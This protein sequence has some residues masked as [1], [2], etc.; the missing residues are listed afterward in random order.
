MEKSKVVICCI[1]S[2]YIHSS[3]APWCLYA[4]VKKYCDNNV[5]PIV[6]EGTINEKIENIKQRLLNEKPDIIGFCSYIWNINTVYDLAKFIKE[7]LPETKVVLGGPEVSYNAKNILIENKNVDFIVSGEGEE[8][9]AK[10]I[11]AIVNRKEPKNIKGVCYKSETELIISEPEILDNDPVSPYCDEYFENLK[12]R[13]AYLETSRGCPYSCA[14]CLSGRCGKA[15][16]FDL[17]RAKREIILLANSGTQTVKLVDR[18]FN[19]NRARAKELYRFIIDN[20]K[21]NIPKG[22]CFHFE[23]AGDILDDETIRILS[24]A[25]VG[26]IQLEIGMQS[27]NEKTLEYINR[28]TNTKKL[29]ENILKLAENNNI[30]IHID[31]IAGLPFEDMESFKSSFNIAFSLNSNMLQLG[32][33]KL[34]HG[35]PMRENPEDFPCEFSKKPPYEVIK[36]PYLN[37]DELD[38]LHCVEDALDRIHNSGRFKR[39]IEYAISKSGIT[40]FDFFAGFAQYISK[41]KVEK[42][43]L[44]KYTE[45]VFNYILTLD[46][47]DKTILRDKMVC[48]RLCTNASGKLPEVLQVKDK[49]LRAYKI[50]LSEHPSYKKQQGIV[51]GVAILYSQN[52]VAYVDYINKNTSEGEYLLNIVPTKNLS[53]E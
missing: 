18:T 31:L 29:R 15:R 45:F 1:N 17:E 10:L 41:I 38:F 39:T 5:L 9:F 25:P 20:Y 12:G 46:N 7:N 37:E 51:R 47:I 19:A 28:K 44:D 27:F 24:S 48:D 16:F 2:K 35:A 21:V 22:V 4:G 42:I 14:F 33:L 50:A 52:S 49:K 43:P 8:A 3:L 40:P 11:N 23:I 32:F 13:I 53:S 30:H 34:L 26:L 36:T 6:V